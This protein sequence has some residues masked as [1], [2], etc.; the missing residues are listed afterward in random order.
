MFICNIVRAR[1]IYFTV[2]VQCIST[3]PIADES[4]GEGAAQ[5]ELAAG[6]ADALCSISCLAALLF[7]VCG[8]DLCPA[9]HVV[10]SLL[11]IWPSGKD[12]FPTCVQEH[13]LRGGAQQAHC[14][15]GEGMPC[16]AL[17]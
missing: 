10:R 2:L 4:C 3:Q 16:A 12:R 7:I 5:T 13:S 8:R 11:H 9:P 6:A 17:F 1:R 15:T 14:M